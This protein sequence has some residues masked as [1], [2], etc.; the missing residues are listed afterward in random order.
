VRIAALYD[1]HGNTP[2][3]EAVLA[4]LESE[5]PD[6]VVFGGDLVSGP[7]PRETLDLMLGLGERARFVRGNADRELLEL[8]EG[9]REPRPGGLSDRWVAEQLTAEERELLRTLPETVVVEVEA[10][11]PVRF[12]HA[13]PRSDEE[14]LTSETPDAYVAAAVAGV[15]EP[16]VVCG[17]THVQYD[18]TVGGTRVVNAGSV[19]MPYADELA[20][21]WAL[22]GPDVE[23]RQTPYDV[24]AAVERVGRSAYPQAAAFVDENMR[25]LPSAA[26]ATALF[27]RMAR[28]RGER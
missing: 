9:R 25:T 14:I 23:F 22:L 12:C 24:E 6:A 7:L 5:A 21:H 15:E 27:E 8:Y 20:A 26:E 1:V 11:G 17:H 16:L 4:E 19:G 28:E 18:R 3:L 2:A 13:T 10:L